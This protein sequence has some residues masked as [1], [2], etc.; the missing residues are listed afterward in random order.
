MIVGKRAG[1]HH[2]QGELV[3]RQCCEHTGCEADL[4]SKS[5]HI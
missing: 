2:P 5:T 3:C 1:P 4:C